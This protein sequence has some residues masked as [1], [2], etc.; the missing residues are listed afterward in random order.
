MKNNS[1]V[2]MV[3]PWVSQELYQGVN[4]IFLGSNPKM[5]YYSLAD[6]YALCQAE[7]Y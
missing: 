2:N 6:C 4:N 5:L 1:H 3:E 7:L